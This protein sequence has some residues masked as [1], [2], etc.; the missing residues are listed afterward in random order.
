M[1]TRF[2]ISL[3]LLVLLGSFGSA[4]AQMAPDPEREIER[5]RL[6]YEESL[7]RPK[8][9]ENPEDIRGR[10]EWFDFQR[11]FPFD[12]IPAGARAAA[13]EEARIME[14][15]LVDSEK[16]SR[17]IARFLSADGWEE[18][19]PYNVGGRVRAIAHH[20]TLPDVLYVGAASG[21]I[22]KSTDNGATWSAA[23]NG[24]TTLA[25]GA[26]AIDF[27]NPDVIYAG[28]GEDTQPTSSYF[29]D[30]LFKSIDGG[31]TW[32]NVGMR[33]ASG[34]SRIITHRQKPGVVYVATVGG[35]EGFFRS[36]DAG[37]TWTKTLA[38]A[39]HDIAV[40]PVD[41]DIVFA[42]FGMTVRR[43]TDGGRTWVVVRNGLPGSGGA[44]VALAAAPSDRNRFYALYA[45]GNSNDT[46]GA[47][48]E[49]GEI[50]RTDDGGANWVKMISFDESF[51]NGQGWYDICLAVHPTRPDIVLAGG[52]DIY[53]SSNGGRTFTNIT[54]IYSTWPPIDIAHADQHTLLFDPTNPDRVLL[55]NDGGVYV[56]T[57]SGMQWRRL[58]LRLPITQ[59]YRMDVD[60][61]DVTRVYGG[62]QDN[63]TAGSISGAGQPW[64][65]I[66]G[67]DG[68]WVAVDP[69]DPTYVYS[70]VYYG[71]QIYRVDTRTLQTE[72]LGW[73]I[74]EQGDWSTPL[75]ISPVDGAIYSG[76][77]DLWRSEND[78]RSWS[79]LGASS[80]NFISSIGLSM[81]NAGHIVVG[82]NNGRIRSS[83]DNG[84][85]W[86]LATGGLS[87][88][89]TDL[90]FDPTRA[91]RVY[92]T[93]SG[94][95]SG[96]VFR[97]DDYGRTFVD[98]S[99]T[100]PDAPANTI[101]IDPADP[102][103]LFVGTDAGV[104]ITLDGGE[105]WLSFND[106]LPPAAVVD[107]KIHGASR[108]LI[109]ATHGRS[110]FR[111]DLSTIDP[112]PLI[113]SPA[114]GTTLQTPSDLVVRWI[115]TEGPVR[116]SLSLDG[117]ASYATIAPRV[118][119]FAW[120]SRLGTLRVPSARIRVEELE[121]RGRRV[122]SRFFALLP[123]TNATDFGL[124]GFHAT[125]IEARGSDL[126]AASLDNDSLYRFRIPLLSNRRT[127]VR[128]GIP[129]I[130]K[131]L[132]YDSRSDIFYLLVDDD[133]R[134]RLFRMDTSGVGEGEIPLP[135]G[136]Y[137]GVAVTPDGI[138][139]STSGAAPELLTI[140]T[141]GN[142]LRHTAPL[143]G[144]EEGIRA[145]LAWDGR[146]LAQGLTLS[147]TNQ[148]YS[149]RLE[150][151]APGDP[152]RVSESI[153]VVLTTSFRS[154][155]AGFAF[156]PADSG[157]AAFYWGI[158]TAGRFYRFTREGL[159]SGVT[160]LPLTAP[161]VRSTATI[162]SITP[163]PLRNGSVVEITLRRGSTLSLDLHAASGARVLGLFEGTLGAGRHS[164]A[165]PAEG[166]PSGLYYLVLRTDTGERVVKAV[167]VAR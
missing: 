38:S 55:G 163:N 57:T 41:N 70:E 31:A 14:S 97:S 73:D 90:R 120:T 51:F 42:S 77:F 109:A 119:G 25:V 123:K 3:L 76:R 160:E 130:A 72:Y 36:S 154:V 102:R 66:S 98:I 129:G 18:I 115:G 63:G 28:S 5:R 117:G 58:S 81:H 69:L 140:D 166:L 134:R 54:N 2:R 44:R 128:T 149:S 82:T 35:D 118:D 110:M 100:L 125:A 50:Y 94:F 24:Q 6:E 95:R 106:Q 33:M 141:A 93:Y 48:G 157:R 15:R 132:G 87:R 112:Q 65:E 79:G 78:G 158:D 167:A 30:G 148:I 105:N 126:W 1:N 34:F 61:T 124:R 84:R 23:I 43:S 49:I 88:T 80:G 152:P 155:F 12:H 26:L 96:H 27:Q 13:I 142:V 151:V 47:N 153:P 156:S 45:R 68:F 11:R 147:D 85:T 159:F 19:G 32:A 91:S 9:E 62:T 8:E 143:V 164:L 17:G 107:L 139:L 46:T 111:F 103:R 121:G 4:F 67:G 150:T 74:P 7:R 145:G 86:Q 64:S 135:P 20:P 162:E 108:T 131:D 127:L 10:Q 40:D 75:V 136:N 16:G 104:F 29:A 113:L 37:A 137:S 21:G 165:I 144:A 99:A 52:I 39:C 161:G 89:V 59:F 22:W 138:V 83:T 92:A 101:A 146:S 116:I 56:S 60:P 133:G 71:S 122:E 53:R 114:R